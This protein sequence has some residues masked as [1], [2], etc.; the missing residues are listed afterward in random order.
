MTYAQTKEAQTFVLIERSTNLKT[1]PISVSY[2][3]RETCPNSCPLKRKL[4]NGV[5]LP[6]EK[7][8]PCYADNGNSALV[9]R[10]KRTDMEYLLWPEYI[11]RRKRL[12]TRKHRDCIG[13][14]QP[15]DG[16]DIDPVRFPEYVESVLHIPEVWTY[17]H[18][19]VVDNAHNA[20]LI[21]WANGKGYIVNLSGDDRTEADALAD[22]GI[23]P[24][25]T[26]LPRAY[27]RKEKRVFTAGKW[28][29]EW[30]ETLEEYKDRLSAL[31]DTTPNGRKVK[32]CP[33][34]FL[35]DFT[36]RDCTWCMNKN[37][38]FIVGFPA[39]G[40]QFKSASQIAAA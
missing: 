7:R 34:T 9:H 19:D 3:D 1:G 29:N 36:C 37:R 4:K 25:V 20:E 23:G 17:S 12:W 31:P 14:D 8:G 27:M 22:L 15:G 2:N 13:G 26:M 24:V 30:A 16:E 5:A 35:D 6:D 39:H 32:V 18:Y 38:N 40:S 33:S 11:E 21:R 10:R 28:H